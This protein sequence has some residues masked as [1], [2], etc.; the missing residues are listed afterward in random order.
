MKHIVFAVIL[1]I[2]TTSG[3][4]ANR[5]KLDYQTY[6]ME[7]TDVVRQ[8]S[9]LR[10]SVLL[11]NMPGYWVSIPK[12]GTFLRPHNDTIGI[13][14]LLGSENFELDK[15]IWMKKSGQHEGT[16]IFEKLPA[17]VKVV[18][19]FRLKKTETLRLWHWEYILMRKTLLP[20]RQCLMPR[21]SSAPPLLA[22][23]EVLIQ[24]DIRIFL[25]TRRMGKLS[26]RESYITIIPL[27]GL[28]LLTFTLKIK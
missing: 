9:C 21:H 24:A 20:H 14:H 19:S 28:T 16:L 1:L 12:N 23:G 13:Y 11:K 18:T 3:L 17:D 2:L 8:D 25:I 6:Y 15:R 4:F 10:I 22:N 27:P 26:S 5:P 7:V